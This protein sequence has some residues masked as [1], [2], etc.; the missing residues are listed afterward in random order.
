MFFP[1]DFLNICCD[2]LFEGNEVLDTDLAIVSHVLGES[3][4][5]VAAVPPHGLFQPGDT[6][7]LETSYLQEVCRKR[8][9]VVLTEFDGQPGL[10]SHPLY[11][12]L[13]ADFY[14]GV[15][16]LVGN[17]IWGVVSF[18]SRSPRTEP[19]SAA[20]QKILTAGAAEISAARPSPAIATANGLPEAE[21]ARGLDAHDDT[22]GGEDV[23]PGRIIPLQSSRA[24]PQTLRA[25]S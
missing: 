5:I 11:H 15:P 17:E 20:D 7:P 16:V 19:V 25:T 21:L 3:H 1:A 10:Q 13:S 2:V 9:V 4:E 12:S 22:S 18:S 8:E 6:F 23:L 14:V 24:H